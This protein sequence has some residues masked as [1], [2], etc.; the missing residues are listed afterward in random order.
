MS[1]FG[2]PA[3]APLG[4]SSKPAT[5][6]GKG[7][8][9]KVDVKMSEEDMRYLRDIAERNYVNKFTTATL[10]PNVK[11]SFGDVRETADV[12]KIKGTIEKMMREEIAVAA[13]GVY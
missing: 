11:I 7:K 3:G 9:G 1:Q 10:A 8:N 2:T 13:E 5:V 6:K 4:S 12:K